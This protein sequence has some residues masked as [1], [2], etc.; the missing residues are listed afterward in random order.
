MV[1]LPENSRTRFFGPAAVAGLILYA[2]AFALFLLSESAPGLREPFKDLLSDKTLILITIGFVATVETGHLVD[3]VRGAGE[4][5]LVYLFAAQGLFLPAAVVILAKG[6]I[7]VFQKPVATN[8]A[9]G[10]GN[11]TGGIRIGLFFVGPAAAV[12]FG[13]IARALI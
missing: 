4:R 6:I 7:L 3:G 13:I 5:L 11:I 8:P 10:A 2:A 12:L 1:E 9:T